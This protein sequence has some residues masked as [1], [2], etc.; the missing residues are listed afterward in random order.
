MSSIVFGGEPIAKL[1]KTLGLENQQVTKLVLTI[2][3]NSACTLEITRF[4]NTEDMEGIR[5]FVETHD[6]KSH[7]LEREEVEV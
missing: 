2:A 4:A 3:V 7:F 1:L 5:E 6:L